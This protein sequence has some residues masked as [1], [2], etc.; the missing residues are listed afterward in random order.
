V[1]TQFPSICVL[2]EYSNRISL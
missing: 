1:S 2:S